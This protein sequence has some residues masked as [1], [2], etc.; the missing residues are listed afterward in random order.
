LGEGRG[1]GLQDAVDILHDLVVPESQ[2]AIAARVQ[3]ARSFRVLRPPFGVSVSIDFDDKTGAF[4]K[5][6]HDKRT[7]GHLP[8]ELGLLEST[9]PQV[10]PKPPLRL[11]H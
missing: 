10:V 11:G 2:H 1:E 4:A 6:V 8:S 7:E 9:C 3:P 5:E